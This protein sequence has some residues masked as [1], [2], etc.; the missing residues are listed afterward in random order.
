MPLCSHKRR[1]TRDTDRNE[2]LRKLN[3]VALFQVVW[4]V[5]LRFCEP[6]C[7]DCFCSREYKLNDNNDDRNYRTIERTNGRL[8]GAGRRRVARWP[9]ERDLIAPVRW[10]KSI[11]FNRD[12]QSPNIS[13]FLCRSYE[14]YQTPTHVTVELF[15]LSISPSNAGASSWRLESVTEDGESAWDWRRWVMVVLMV[16]CGSICRLFFFVRARSNEESREHERRR[17][18]CNRANCFRCL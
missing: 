1:T 2:A 18:H 7:K 6:L 17:D 9:N 10:L 11:D 16:R 14:F 15:G 3:R 12:F 13:G 5:C 4:F 8:V